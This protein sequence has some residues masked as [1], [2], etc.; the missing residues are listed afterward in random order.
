M[1]SKSWRERRSKPHDRSLQPHVR[2]RNNINRLLD[3]YRQEGASDLFQITSEQYVADQDAETRGT[4]N[5]CVMKKPFWMF[6]I[7]PGGFS[8]WSA[9]TTFGNIEEDTLSSPV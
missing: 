7:G 1:S 3:G 5:P 4:A 6:Q 8:A 2:L 9:R